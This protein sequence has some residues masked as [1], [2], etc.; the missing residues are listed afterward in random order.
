MG[1]KTIQLEGNL[2]FASFK[3]ERR[4]RNEENGIEATTVVY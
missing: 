2:L 3:M 4:E 1:D